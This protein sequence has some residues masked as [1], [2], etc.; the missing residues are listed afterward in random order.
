MKILL[1][2]NLLLISSHFA[3]SQSVLNS[4]AVEK[5]WG[6]YNKYKESAITNRFMK[7]AEM[8]PL[9][10]K[11]VNSKFITKDEIGKSVRNRSINH[12]TAGRGKT[13]VMLW[14]QMHGDESTATMAL[15]DMF[16]FLSATDDND[17]L[18]KL[19]LDNLELHVVPML[20]P[21]GAQAWKRRN[22]LEIDVNRDARMLVTPEGQALMGLARKL[23]PQIGFNLH[24]QNYLYSSGRSKNSATISFL[25]PAYNYPKDMNA[26]RK[27]ATQIILS[28]NRAL[29]T[30]SPGNVA[31]YNDDFDPRCFGD[32]FQG[33]G[34]STILI[35]SGGYYHDPEKQFIRQ[36]NFL[37]LLS[38]FESI[39]TASYE[40]ENL[41]DYELIPENDNSLYDVFVKNV[42]IN[43]EG[44]EF[45]TH[46]GINRSQ[47][48]SSDN[49]GM[50]YNGRIAELGDQELV[51]GYDEIDA[52]GLKFT[53]AKIKTMRR[54][55]WERL[56][57][58]DELDLI[59]QGF[60]FVKWSDA[61]SPTGAIKNRL[62]NLTNGKENQVQAAG[63]GQPAQFLLTKEGKPVI[64]VVNGYKVVLDEPAKVLSNTFGY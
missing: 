8:I 19:I 30:K 9:I 17:N 43:K 29:Q 45:K 56:T 59:K 12:L 5:V 46:L 3:Q 22:D 28:M 7:H 50:T 4:P 25:A 10:Q 37:A 24:D 1:I 51:F 64:A 33:M 63:I 62:L 38:A 18:R 20:N 52:T 14:S 11:H 44:Y 55:E 36:L 6:Q 34:I 2:L 39:A 16:N 57:P 47:I 23:Q 61:K 31:K 35:E 40:K 32:T 54:A 60:L 41:R 15:F 13:K 27:R 42:T 26:V 49:A 48:R 53:P 58:Q 21:D